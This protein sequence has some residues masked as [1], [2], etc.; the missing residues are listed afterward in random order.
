MCMVMMG[1]CFMAEV[2]AM[3]MVMMGGVFDGG[4]SSYVYGHDGGS[5]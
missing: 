3:Y 4:G 2:V 5:V 1:E